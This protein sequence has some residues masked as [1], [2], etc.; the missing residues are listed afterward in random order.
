MIDV[1]FNKETATKVHVIGK[2]E[3]NEP[4]DPHV[5]WTLDHTKNAENS[6]KI[7]FFPGIDQENTYVISLGDLDEIS[8]DDVRTLGYKLTKELQKNQESEAEIHMPDLGFC[9]RKTSMAFMEG[10]F[11]AD[12]TF[13]KKTDS[14]DE[15]K[16]K[17]Q[18]L[19]YHYFPDHGPEEKHEEGFQ[20]VKDQMAGVYLARNLVNET[21][22]IIY[23]E[24][25]AQAAKENL[26]EVGV[27][28]SIYGKDE[29]ED[30]GMEAYLS[31]AKGSDKEPKLIVMEYQGDPES[32]QITGLVGK[33]LTYDSGGYSLK[34]SKGM[35]TMHSDMGGAGSVIGTMLALGKSQ[36][37]VNVTAVVAAAENLVSGHAYKVGDIIGSMSGKTIEVLNTDAEGR[38][39]LADAIYYITSEKNVDRVIDL[40]TLT[41]ACLSALGEEYTGAISNN[42][43]FYK[44]FEDAAKEAGEKAWLLPNDETFAEMNRKTEVADLLNSPGGLAGTITAG[45]FVGEFLADKDIPWIHLDIAGTAYRSKANKYLPERATGVHVKTLYNLLN[46]LGAC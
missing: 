3:K 28:V 35:S 29:I 27:K 13:S 24:S 11:H 45:Q 2:G 15:N 40:A 46:P 9:Q 1:K 42:Q 14:K 22:N 18:D 17:N 26:E 4:K 38:L 44:E 41:G 6:G 20:R 5:Q 32:N 31:V 25:L 12:Y 43:D 7:S 19:V 23:P 10:V 33:G 16:D 34:P 8:L 30:L 21:S 37:K 39:T 36:A